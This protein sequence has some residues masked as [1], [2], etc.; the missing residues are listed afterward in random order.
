M[1]KF[2]IK[3]KVILGANVCVCC[4]FSH[5]RP[6]VTLWT[7]ALQVPLSMGFSRQEYGVGCHAI[8]QGIFQ[9]RDG[10]HISCVSC[11]GRRTLYHYVSCEVQ[12]QMHTQVHIHMT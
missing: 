7:L 4:V 11:I 8:L 1:K 10:T 3:W 12:V 9:A 2:E 6:F 5:V